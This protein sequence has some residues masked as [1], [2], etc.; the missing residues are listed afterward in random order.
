MTHVVNLTASPASVMREVAAAIGG[1]TVCTRVAAKVVQMLM[2][3]M[4]RVLF[5]WLLPTLQV[6]SE[7][8]G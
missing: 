4:A 6:Y 8:G 2:L 5:F 7:K 3:V 1:L